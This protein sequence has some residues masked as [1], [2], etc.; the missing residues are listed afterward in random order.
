V[1]RELSPLE[2]PDPCSFGAS[3][4][5]LSAGKPVTASQSLP[6][7]PPEGAV[8]GGEL[9]K[10]GAGAAP[11]QWIEIDLGAPATITEIALEVSQFPDGHTVHRV[12]GRGPS[13]PEQL[14]AL[15]QGTTHDGEWLLAP[16][17]AAAWTGIRFVRV[18]TVESPS[19]VSWFEIEVIGV[20]G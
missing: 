18:E 16:K 3:P 7:E 12:Y 6:G 17:G 4:R 13:G 11:P 15:L 14:L 2:R 19:W 8:D 9:A 5:N 1:N 20:P 10:W